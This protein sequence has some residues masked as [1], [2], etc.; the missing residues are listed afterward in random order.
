MYSYFLECVDNSYCNINK[1]EQDVDKDLN[2]NYLEF[3]L[4]NKLIKQKENIY[5]YKMCRQKLEL[6]LL[7]K[8]NNQKDKE[9]IYNN[10]ELMLLNKIIKKNKNDEINNMYHKHILFLYGLVAYLLLL[11]VI[12]VMITY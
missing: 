7:N 6:M 11:N 5:H 4:L 8:I 3:V 12:C 1:V 2:K 10:L 9:Q